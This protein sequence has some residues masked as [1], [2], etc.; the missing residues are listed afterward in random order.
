M[1]THNHPR[2]GRGESG[3]DGGTFSMDDIYSLRVGMKELRA[4]GNEGTYSMK[5]TGTA[6]P[7][8]LHQ[9]LLNDKAVIVRSQREIAGQVEMAYERGRYQTKHDAKVDSVN[10]QMQV[11][12]HWYETNAGKYGYSYSFTPEGQ[13]EA[14]AITPPKRRTQKEIDRDNRG[15]Y[16]GKRKAAE[17]KQKGMASVNRET[18]LISMGYKK[19][20]DGSFK[21]PKT[22][23]VVKLFQMPRS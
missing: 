22:G 11:I 14:V 10:R 21:H 20:P 7:E 13:R 19:Q 6:S 3:V 23:Q 2:K 12:H 15:I 4:V 1:A 9:A 16:Y 5:A 8:G 17:Q 18:L